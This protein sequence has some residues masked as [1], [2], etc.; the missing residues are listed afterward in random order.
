MVDQSTTVARVLIAGATG[1]T[2]RAVVGYARD[3]G[4]AV[5]ALTSDPAKRAMLAEMGVDDV[6]VGDLMDAD[7][8]R[9]AVAGVDAVLC[10]V[11]PKGEGARR[12]DIFSVGV[13][14][15]IEAA[16]ASGARRF[17]LEAS[18]GVGDSAPAIPA[19]FREVIG[20]VLDAMN[21]AEERLRASGLAYTIVRPGGLTDDA[22]T[23][24]VVVGEGGTAIGSGMIPRADV[25]RLM[26]AALFTP[27][28]EDR[29]F[30][31]V[32]RAGLR[33]APRATVSIPWR[34]MA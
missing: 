26:V 4:L 1:G 32:S 17:V 11:G 12:T 22:A 21:V 7:D 16:R 3:A 5:R 10:A 19:Q 18:I 6:V 14:N 15:L 33:G 20:A 34:F 9:R 27:E 2:G 23:H 30:E 24:D 13:V 25:A 28:A 8:A 31:L 29:T